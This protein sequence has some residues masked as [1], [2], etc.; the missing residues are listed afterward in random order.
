MNT[1]QSKGQTFRFIREKFA[2]LKTLAKDSNNEEEIIRT[3]DRCERTLGDAEMLFTADV[4][5]GTE[6][7]TTIGGRPV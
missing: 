1:N 4:I 6:V 2:R 7:T 3:L 5:Q